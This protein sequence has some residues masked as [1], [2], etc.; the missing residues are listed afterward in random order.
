M[1]SKLGQL[2][3]TLSEKDEKIC[4]LNNRKREITVR[5]HELQSE[6][7]S[8]RA[9]LGGKEAAYNEVASRQALEEHRLKDEQAKIVERRKQLMAIGGAKV[10]KMMEREIEI[11]TRSVQSLEE[12]AMKV[13]EEG[14]QLNKVVTEIKEKLQSLETTLNEETPGAET[15]LKS[16]DSE[17]SGLTSER[18][19]LFKQL[20][21]RLQRLYK[22]VQGRY[23]GS[24][25]A[26]ASK[27]SCR[28][29]FRALPAQTYNQILAGYYLIQC[30]GCARI[31]VYT[32]D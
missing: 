2:L 23:P 32:E 24:P 19:G 13:M 7:A 11:A 3:L 14:D 6:I 9:E 26:M 31:L 28:A 22:R 20:E 15:E 27:S 5:R 16:M 4:A 21:P 18:D 12:A 1:D 30:P 29:C 17:L 10:A 8:L 25:V